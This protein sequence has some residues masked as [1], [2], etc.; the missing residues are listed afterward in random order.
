MKRL[1]STLT[2]LIIVTLLLM[3]TLTSAA[4]NNNSKTN[5][6][7]TKS[8]KPAKGKKA[9]K[10]VL[11]PTEEVEVDYTALVLNS[12]VNYYKIG[13]DE[14]L[15]IQTDKQY[16]SSGESIWFKGY[17]LNAITHAPINHTNFI[18]VELI[19]SEGVLVSRVKVQRDDDG[20]NGYISMEP[21]ITPGDYSLRG[22]TKWMTNKDDG[23]FYCKNIKIVSAITETTAEVDP[24]DKAAVR[25]AARAKAQEA[26]AAAKAERAAAAAAERSLNYSVQFFPEG[27]P[28]V[29][30]TSQIVA[31]KALAEDGLSIE[32]SGVIRNSKGEEVADISTTHNGMG[33]FQMIAESGD[34]YVATLSMP[35]G[36]KRTFKLPA[37]DPNGVAIK[38][39]RVGDK[40]L[41][42]IMTNSPDL[43]KGGHVVIHSRGHIITVSDATLTPAAISMATLRSGVS[44]FAVVDSAGQVI[45][46]RLIFKK[47]TS[48]PTM[49][50]KS[51]A[52]N[53]QAR[54]LATFRVSVKDENGEPAKGSF[55]V[56]VT[57][58]GSVESDPAKDN[59]MSYL[60]LSSDIKGYIEEPGLYFEENT[61]AMDYKLDLLMRTQAWRRFDLT[62]LIQNR[63][64]KPEVLYEDVAYIT[65]SVKGFFGNEARRPRVAV[66]CSK[67]NYWDSF[68]LDASSRFRLVGLNIPDS[69][70][71]IVKAQGRNGGNSMTLNID[72][73]IYP[74]LS[75]G[76]FSRKELA[77]PPVAFVNQSKDKFFY[78][79]GMQ[80]I[81][82]ESISVTTGVRAKG[83]DGAFATQTTT[84]EILATMTGMTLKE[85]IGT[86][87]NMSVGETDVFYRGSSEAVKFMVDGVDDEYLNLTQ[88]TADDIEQIDFFTGADAAAFSDATGGVFTISLKAVNLDAAAE[89]ANLAYVTP[90]GYQHPMKFFQPAYENAS[91]RSTWPPDFRSTI[92]WD[93]KIKPDSYGN[94]NFGFYTADKATS[95]TV[96]IEGVTDSG[97]VCRG[98][99][100]I[101]RTLASF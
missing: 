55:A 92:Y 38:V 65:G 81:E 1:L 43:I 22:Y 95:Y 61:P 70:T 98:T 69:T 64:K 21:T 58:N 30:N 80:T 24:S 37:V 14:K 51:N 83:A 68:E 11:A 76:I 45:A 36:E 12:F 3:P 73:E 74:M 79:G 41:Y 23:F 99:T 87:P 9:G 52:T 31:F 15:Y 82:L 77:E 13:I 28:L 19:N 72:P 26:A 27:G 90:L 34:Q 89:L 91:V 85:V 56:S 16:Y 75:A 5:A 59:M 40:A 42:Q 32:V 20:F 96:T 25:A 18:Y 44:T 94:I 35:D 71:Y 78:E 33:L 93:G 53:Y 62:A 100:T 57:D 48:E 88:L 2:Q 66:M 7:T 60:L 6:A 63:V 50:F 47:P 67:V 84:R 10:G 54:S 46:E 8:S 29:A 4:T 97:E 101:D 49:T 86:F 39:T 17:L